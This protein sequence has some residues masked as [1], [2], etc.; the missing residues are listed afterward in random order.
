MKKDKKSYIEHRKRLRERFRKFDLQNLQDYEIIELLLT[1]S[2]P[3]RDVK[4]YAKQ[5]IKKFGTIKEIF[6]ATPKEL[7]E[8]KYIKDKTI[9]LIKFIKQINSLY[10][11][12]KASQ[13]VQLGDREKLIEYCMDKIGNEQKEIFHIIYLD[14]SLNII[15][16][17]SFPAFDTVFK[18]S[19]NR[20]PVHIKEILTEALDKK[21]S[22]FVITHNHPK[23]DCLPS[24]IDAKITKKIQ[25]GAESLDI[26][27]FD[28][29]IVNEKSYYSFMENGL[30]KKMEKK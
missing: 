3:V 9:D 13:K 25:T 22:A 12:E 19:V 23:A 2:I 7:E 8:I 24:E 20:A 30:L 14:N 28:H 5:L 18:G 27:L 16:D 11:K 21:A 6:E 17:K 1:F 4:P 10:K 26:V 15:T 29:I